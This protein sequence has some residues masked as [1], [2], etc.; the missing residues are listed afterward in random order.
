[1]ATLQCT[2]YEE[3][4]LKL[5]TSPLWRFEWPFLEWP[6]VGKPSFV[7]FRLGRL[8]PRPERTHSPFKALQSGNGPLWPVWEW[9]LRGPVL[10]T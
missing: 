5:F 6:P 1:M 3:E 8:F 2:P 10:V 9:T 4:N 7:A